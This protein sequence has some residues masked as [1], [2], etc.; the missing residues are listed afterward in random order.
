MDILWAVL[1]C[2]IS[3]LGFVGCFLPVLPGPPLNYVAF[4]LLQ[5]RSDPPFSA[6]F[7]WIWVA[8]I[9]LISVLEYLIPIYGAKRFGGSKFGV[10]GTAIGLIVGLFFGVVGII[11]GPFVGALIGELWATQNSSL[12]FKAA[13]GSFIGFVV[14][15]LLKVIVSIVMCYYVV[16]AIV[17]F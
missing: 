15:S 7:M 9:V 3:I 13:F 6:K 5:L 8:I 2:I 12:A 1:A 10:W 4:L 11:V 16:K 17:I 14:G